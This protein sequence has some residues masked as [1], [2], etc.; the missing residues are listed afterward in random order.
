[1]RRRRWRGEALLPPMNALVKKKKTI[2]TQTQKVNKGKGK[3]G[4]GKER[5]ARAP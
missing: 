1:M 5:T 2:F 4:K 3:E